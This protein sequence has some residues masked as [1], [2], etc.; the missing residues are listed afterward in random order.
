[1]YFEANNGQLVATVTPPAGV[2][3]IATLQ[4]HLLPPQIGELQRSFAAWATSGMSPGLVTP[5][6]TWC[7]ADGRLFFIFEGGHTPQPLTHVGLA[8]E[9]AAWLVMLDQWM[10]TFVVVARA[11]SVWRNEELAAALSFMTTAFLPPALATANWQRVAGALAHVV[12]EGPLTEVA[13]Q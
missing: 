6:R 12:A 13:P 8:R 1:M 5:A 3:P 4:Q 2:A 10:E 7:N 9:L 11:R